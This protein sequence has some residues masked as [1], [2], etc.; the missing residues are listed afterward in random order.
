MVLRVHWVM[1][2]EL[3]AVMFGGC[4]RWLSRVVMWV[5]GCFAGDELVGGAAFEVDRV[6]RG[7]FGIELVRSVG[8][9]VLAPDHLARA[10][11]MP[12]EAPTMSAVGIGRPTQ[13]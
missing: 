9:G 13:K 8:Q 6:G 12:V 10:R 7:P 5:I 1:D 2:L 3:V 11:P 4:C